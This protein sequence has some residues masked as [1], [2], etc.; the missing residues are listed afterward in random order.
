MQSAYVFP[1]PSSNPSCNRGHVMA[2]TSK[3]GFLYRNEYYRCNNCGVTLGC[4]QGR[5]WCDKCSYDL[6][7]SCYPHLLSDN[8]LCNGC[9]QRHPLSWTLSSY[10]KNGSKVTRYF[11]NLCT[12]TFPC[13]S[14][15]WCCFVCEFDICDY[16]VNFLRCDEGHKL[17]WCDTYSSSYPFA[18]YFCNS[19]STE[20]SY[21]L[22]RWHCCS[23][24]FDLCSSCATNRVLAYS[25]ESTKI[26][27]MQSKAEEEVV[28]LEVMEPE[29]EKVTENESKPKKSEDEKFLCKICMDNV[30][31]YVLLPCGHTL[32]KM[33]TDPINN[34]PFDRKAVT[35]KMQIF[36]PCRFDNPTFLDT[37]LLYTSDAADERSSVDLGGRRIIKKKKKK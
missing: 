11:C 34:C 36:F 2:W 4:C 12:G 33:C 31:E 32:C 16:C 10:S 18:K 25:N 20:N 37:C 28:S 35:Q 3:A 29:V 8:A 14:G 7:P 19:C 30:V 6:C 1:Q 24:E 9:P 27:V 23:C 21:K 26:E 5:W 17:V 15:R 13:C 22:G